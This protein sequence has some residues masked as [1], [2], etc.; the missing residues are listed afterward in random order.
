MTRAQALAGR[1]LGGLAERAGRRPP[2]CQTRAKGWVGELLEACLGATAGSKSRPDFERIGVELKSIPINAR[3]LPSESTYVCVAPL[4]DLTELTWETS[5][6]RHK[7][8]RV[9]W[10]P[11]QADKA[12]PLPDRRVG[13]PLIWSANPE[14]EAALRT[15]WTEL[16]DM[17]RMGRVEEITAHS[18]KYLQIRPKAADS[19]ARTWGVDHNG[20]RFRTMPR[21]FYLRAGFTTLI[22]KRSFARVGC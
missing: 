8:A 15:D 2:E 17:I 6:V 5:R 11:V 3:N 12:I 18:G 9:L 4:T 1:T 19:H 14:E 7:M 10:V 16:T 21:G 20:H 13:S 22:L